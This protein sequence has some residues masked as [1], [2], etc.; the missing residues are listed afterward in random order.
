LCCIVLINLHIFAIHI[1]VL[2]R[3]VFLGKN[4]IECNESKKMT[5]YS[6]RKTETEYNAGNEKTENRKT[7]AMKTKNNVQK[8]IL[9]SLAVVLSFVLISFTVNAQDFWKKLL[10]NSSF[11][12]IA[13]AMVEKTDASSVSDSESDSFLL[14]LLEDEYEPV[15]EMESWMNNDDYFGVETFQISEEIESQLELEDWMTND[16]L[17]QA[18]VNEEKPLELEAWMTSKKIW[19]I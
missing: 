17:F 9:R 11:N 5:S 13:L 14:L 4:Y 3:V 19:E 8:T 15:L 2:A 6:R 10:E 18:K 1:T 7:K 12:E 16:N